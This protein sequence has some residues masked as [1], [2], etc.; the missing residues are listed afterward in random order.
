MEVADS[1]LAYDRGEKSELYAEVGISD[2]WIVN[3]KER[4]IEVRRRASGSVFAEAQVYAEGEFVS[5]LEFP[6]LKLPVAS[7][8]AG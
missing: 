7:V 5:P 8:I 1:S 2:Y 6:Q 4:C 3:V